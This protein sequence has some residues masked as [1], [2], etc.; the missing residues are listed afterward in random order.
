MYCLVIGK[1]GY[2]EMTIGQIG[3][4]LLVSTE[5]NGKLSNCSFEEKKKILRESG[6]DV[7]TEIRNAKTWGPKEIRRRTTDL[8]KKAHGE[9][10]RIK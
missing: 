1:N 10:W 5:L 7:P 9:V 2:D 8:V 3:N 6:Y 4:L